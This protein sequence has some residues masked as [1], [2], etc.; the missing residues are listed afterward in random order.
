MT[1]CIAALFDKGLSCAVAADPML[2][3][4]A[5][6]I[7][8]RRAECETDKYC[9]IAERSVL[10]HSGR[11]R[12]FDFILERLQERLK[13][14]SARAADEVKR[15]VWE[16]FDRNRQA[17]IAQ[18]LGGN[19][20]FEKLVSTMGNATAG[21]L[22]QAWK[23][24]KDKGMLGYVG[25]VMLAHWTGDR[26]EILN[27]GELASGEPV[28]AEAAYSS[29]GSG[30]FYATAGFA[31]QGYAIE[32]PLPE[33]VFK[34]YCAKR[35]AEANRFVGE[36]TQM[37]YMRRDSADLVSLTK[38]QIQRLERLR[39]ARS[40]LTKDEARAIGL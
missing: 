25:Q 16:L 29:I 8:E 2:V 40:A 4:G 26:Y 18:A 14:Y 22:Y 33:A 21:S 7:I 15:A 39:R 32:D 11:S 10:L 35:A 6:Q 20:D 13:N 17:D 36:A 27:Y 3:Y 23:D 34:V 24:V 38:S 28:K 30:M 9:L 12:D 37:A 5:N 1:I 31:F 19:Y